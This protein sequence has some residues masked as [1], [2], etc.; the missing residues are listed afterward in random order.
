M[1]F[2]KLT[3]IKHEDRELI[4][5]WQFVEVNSAHRLYYKVDSA[6]VGY[7]FE[8]YSVMWVSCAAADPDFELW[9][10]ESVEVE[11]GIHGVAYFDGIRHLYWGDEFTNNYGYHYYPKLENEIAVLHALRELEKKYCR[12]YE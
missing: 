3:E 1:E 2:K 11:C 6:G 7:G 8:F 12:D 9:D 10:L 5:Q 4:Y